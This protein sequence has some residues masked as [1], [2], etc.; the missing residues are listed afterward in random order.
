MLFS[1]AK[2]KHQHASFQKQAQAI[3]D[4]VRLYSK[5]GASPAGGHKESGSD[6]RPP[7][8]RGGR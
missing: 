2:H 4:K 8:R 5:I 6:L 3:N 1:G 7:I